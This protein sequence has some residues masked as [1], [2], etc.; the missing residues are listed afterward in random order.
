MHQLQRANTPTSAQVV[1]K[2]INTPAHQRK[3]SNTSTHQLQ[4]TNMS[5]HQHNHQPINTLRAANQ[6]FNFNTQH[7]NTSNTATHRSINFNTP[8]LQH[9]R[10]INPSKHLE[11]QIEPSTP[12]HKHNHTSAHQSVN[13]STHQNFNASTQSD[14]QREIIVLFVPEF[15]S[16]SWKFLSLQEAF[17]NAKTVMNNN[18]SR[19]GKFTKLL[20]CKSSEPSDIIPQRIIGTRLECYLLEK[21]RVVTQEV[22]ERN[23]HV[24]FQMFAEFSDQPK[25]NIEDPSKFRY[26]T[27]TPEHSSFHTLSGHS[28]SEDCEELLTGLSVL[29][30]L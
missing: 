8:T 16:F 20:F 7:I 5:T 21:S 18:S 29:R 24:F 4:H 9:N 19:F 1:M 15:C 6:S 28:D 14:V 27:Q 23:F 17:G 3:Y 26:L 13:T 10:H 30:K 22:G 25:L 2:A 11:Q 12:T